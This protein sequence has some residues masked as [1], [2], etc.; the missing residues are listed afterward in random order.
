[1]ERTEPMLKFKYSAKDKRYTMDFRKD[2]RPKDFKPITFIPNVSST[3]ARRFNMAILGEECKRRGIDRKD[4][5]VDLDKIVDINVYI[6]LTKYAQMNKEVGISLRDMYVDDMIKFAT[7]YKDEE[8]PLSAIGVTYDLRRGPKSNSNKSLSRTLK[9]FVRDS[10][11]KRFAKATGPEGIDFSE[12]IEVK[13]P[14]LKDKIEKVINRGK[15]KKS[16]A[17]QKVMEFRQKQA[18]IEA[19]AAAK[20]RRKPIYDKDER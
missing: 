18:K 15:P 2:V 7:R 20:A 3:F 17:E 14:T 16:I 12:T 10:R 5:I 8:K 9:D 1:M 4:L 11:I 6:M 13:S 19:K